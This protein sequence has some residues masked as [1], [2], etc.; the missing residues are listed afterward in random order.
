MMLFVSKS[1]KELHLI[2]TVGIQRFEVVNQTE[3]VVRSFEKKQ[4]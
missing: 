4:L 2:R 3:K 1:N